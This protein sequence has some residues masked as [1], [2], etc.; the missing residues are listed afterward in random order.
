MGLVLLLIACAPEPG[1]VTVAPTDA[2]TSSTP[3]VDDSGAP[4]CE[5]E[6][7]GAL[8][9]RYIEPLVTDAHPASCNDCHLAGVDLSMW[10][11][12]TPCQSMACMV[13][14]DLVS[15]SEPEASRVLEFITQGDPV[16]ELITDEVRQREYDGFLEWITW[17]ATCHEAVCPT[18]EDA[19]ATDGASTPL[20]EGVASPL[21]ACDEDALTELFLDKVMAWEGRCASCH[22]TDGSGRGANPTAPVFF[23]QTSDGSWARGTMYSLI[24]LGAVDLER[25]EASELLTKP[26]AEGASVTTSIG[27]VVGIAHGGGDKIHVEDNEA[28]QTLYD[29]VDWIAYYADCSAR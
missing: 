6:A 9:D 3:A 16:S 28:E 22:W 19:C 26:L 25:P 8:Y 5:D 21:G 24:G 23:A 17:S 10:V 27:T 18:Y 4:T 14:L 7:Q 20:P 12:D 15:L 11:R 1:K 29:F 2:P 13:N